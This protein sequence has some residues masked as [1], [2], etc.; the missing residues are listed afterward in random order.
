MMLPLTAHH[1]QTELFQRQAGAPLPL[2][3]RLWR[4]TA[5]AKILAQSRTLNRQ[6]GS[7]HGLD[8]MAGRVLVRNA[9]T[10]EAL[11][12]RVYWPV[13]F[14]DRRYRR[15]ADQ[16][17][18]N[19]LLDYGYAIVRAAVARALCGAGLH[20]GLPLHHHNRYDPY[21]LANDL[22]EPF[23]PLVDGWV[24]SW[25]S[26]KPG[27][28]PLDRQA[29]ASLLA[30]LTGRFSACGESRTLFDWA[31]RCAERLARCIEGKRNAIEFPPLEPA[32]G[33]DPSG[34]QTAPERVPGDVAHGDV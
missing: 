31:E 14:D 20:P 25:C 12:S 4:E 18:R 10:I 6:T 19:A 1:L 15:S 13:L 32:P 16:D 22:M 27:P 23:R 33:S 11:A 26:A 30:F 5:Q 24:S 7:T 21:P 9:S 2:K 34:S 17:S 29:K 8:K 3:K 28:W